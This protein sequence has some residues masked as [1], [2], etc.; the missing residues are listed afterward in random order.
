M[1]RRPPTRW[2]RECCEQTPLTPRAIKRIVN[3][4]KLLKIIWHR[5]NRHDLPAQ[6][7]KHAFLAFLC[8]SAKYPHAMRHLFDRISK[9]LDEGTEVD[10]RAE[11]RRG[12]ESSSGQ[13]LPAEREGL[14]SNLRLIPQQARLRPELRPTFELVR[15]LSFA[16]EVGYNPQEDGPFKTESRGSLRLVKRRSQVEEKREC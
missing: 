6:V 13:I 7:V 9:S 10:L 8:L 14:K 11:L 16:A 2:L 1:H 15:S 12:A 4:F 3:A 5:P